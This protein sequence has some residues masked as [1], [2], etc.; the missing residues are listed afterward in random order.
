M[1]KNYRI[2]IVYSK[3]ENYTK[4]FNRFKLPTIYDK[5]KFGIFLRI[6]HYLHFKN[7]CR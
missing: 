6:R 7:C 5:R 4:L 1:L 3:V 2:G